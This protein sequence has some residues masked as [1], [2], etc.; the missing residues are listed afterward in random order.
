MT[1]VGLDP[2]GECGQQHGQAHAEKHCAGPIE[3]SGSLDADFTQRAETPHRPAHAQRYAD[4]EDCAPIP[5]RQQSA[6]QQT[7]KLA[8]DG[9]DL[10]DPQRH[11]ALPGGERVGQD[12]RRTGHQHGPADALDH[13]PAN[14]PHRAAAEVKRVERQRNGGDRENRETEV[15]D[16]H[17]AEDVAEAPER[18]DEHRGHHQVAHQHPQQVADVSWRQRVQADAAENGRQ[19]DQHD[20]GIDGSQQRAQCRVGQGNPLVAGM[21]LIN[22]PAAPRRFGY[23]NLFGLHTGWIR[24]VNIPRH[25]SSLISFAPQSDLR[26][27]TTLGT[28]QT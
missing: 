18:E 16:A 1:A 28:H 19:R 10:V 22:S 13:A 7:Q 17:P 24:G 15:V 11:A 20:R 6:D 27:S 14:Q 12:G 5:F 26:W 9:G 8:G 4:P 25:Q 21:P 2:V 3:A 23:R